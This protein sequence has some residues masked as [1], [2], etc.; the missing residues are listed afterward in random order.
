MKKVPLKKLALAADEFNTLFDIAGT[1]EAIKTK[2]VSEDYIIGKLKEAVDL[3]TETDELTIETEQV[4]IDLDLIQGDEVPEPEDVTIED[5]EPEEL[6]ED[7]PVQKGKV[8]AKAT[9]VSE[10]PKKAAK[11]A[12]K[13]EKPVKE[14][15]EKEPKPE[16]PVKEKKVKPEKFSS[17]NPYDNNAWV[18]ALALK[19][20]PATKKEWA[21]KVKELREANGCQHSEVT[22]KF[23]IR[24]IPFIL[25]VYGIKVNV[26]K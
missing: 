18:A 23:W 7:I 15:K 22:T 24:Y 13:P 12:P 9:E 19:D 26:P 5:D 16:K 4:L 10:L 20:K 3:L 11:V 8:S 21:E 25:D 1:E 2:G 14:K 17:A 6:T